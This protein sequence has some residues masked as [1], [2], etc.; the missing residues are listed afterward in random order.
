MSSPSSDH[1]VVDISIRLRGLQIS[2]S[3]PAAQA[4]RFV[5]EITEASQAQSE[6]GTPASFSV[7]GSE[8][9]SGR[10][11]RPETRAEIEA[12]FRSSCPGYLLDSTSR[13]AGTVE[14]S[15]RRIRRAYRAGQWARA[16][17]SGRVGS[18]NRSEQL[19]LRPRF[20]V[21]L[22]A[23]SISTP[24]VVTTSAAYRGIV[25]DLRNSSSLSHSF[26][27]ETEARAYCEGAEVEFPSVQ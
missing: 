10:R 22:R 4:T 13:L 21:I 20:Y 7:L 27:S 19:P 26:P 1:D 25:G 11:S 3:G 16:V 18:P 14:S 5:T 12:S 24:T 8:G 6:A 9:G 2:V 17:L 15:E 23:D